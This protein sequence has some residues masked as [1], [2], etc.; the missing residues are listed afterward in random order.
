M[1]HLIDREFRGMWLEIMKKVFNHD[2]KANFIIVLFIIILYKIADEISKILIC[3]LTKNKF[4]E[5]STWRTLKYQNTQIQV[6][7]FEPF[8][9]IGKLGSFFD[10]HTRRPKLQ[11]RGMH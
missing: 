11:N 6:K 7:K 8:S 10:F 1:E 3:I 5:N 2:R 9:K 4:D